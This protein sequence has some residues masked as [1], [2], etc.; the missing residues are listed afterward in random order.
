M[1][2]R[3][4]TSWNEDIM[5]KKIRS[6]ARKRDE[7]TKTAEEIYHFLK[8]SNFVFNVENI[9][10]DSCKRSQA[11]GL[12]NQAPTNITCPNKDKEKKVGLINQTP[13]EESN[14]CN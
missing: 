8:E 3:L 11:V 9:G 7:I 10:S 13:P 14:S 6:T 5:I 1:N 2:F 4:K 12:I